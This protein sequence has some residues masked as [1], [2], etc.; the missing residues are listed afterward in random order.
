M[1]VDGI[2][3]GIVLDHIKAGKSMEIYHSLHLDELDCCIAIIKNV[4]STKFGR[5]DII[6]VD[7]EIELDLDVL[8]YIDPHITVNFIKD[9]KLYDK[10]H[11]TL[12]SK[13]TNIIRC[14]NPRCITST[15]QEIDHVFR[16]ADA[17]TGKYQCVYCETVYAPKK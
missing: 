3:S 7:S 13:L 8:G 14:N 16:L 6:K 17:E 1:N 5:K 11:L 15:E 4:R 12:P 10:K 9:G 2:R